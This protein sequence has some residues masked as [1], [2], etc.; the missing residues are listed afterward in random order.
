MIVRL[1]K[2]LHRRCGQFHCC[3]TGFNLVDGDGCLKFDLDQ[4]AAG[5][6]DPVAG[7]LVYHQ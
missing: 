5:K 6:V 3:Q 7:S 1:A 4:G 2:L